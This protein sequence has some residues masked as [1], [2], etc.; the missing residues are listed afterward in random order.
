M[1][2]TLS[3]IPETFGNKCSLVHMVVSLLMWLIVSF[4]WHISWYGFSLSS[5]TELCISASWSWSSPRDRCSTMPA[6]SESPSTL[7]VVRKRSLR[8]KKSNKIYLF[9]KKWLREKT[10]NFCLGYTINLNCCLTS[11][12]TENIQTSSIPN[13]SP[14]RW[15]LQGTHR[16]QSTAMISVMSSVGSPTD[17]NTITMVTRPAWGMPAAP[18]LA[19]VAVILSGRWKG[20]RGVW[21]HLIKGNKQTAY[22]PPSGSSGVM[23]ACEEPSLL[24]Y[25]PKTKLYCSCLIN[26]Y[27]T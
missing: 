5:S 10:P 17:V 26:L 7:V 16:N 13:Q 19:A 25:Y 1:T 21:R 12:L 27:H 15:H 3:L 6:P 18:M 23:K 11:D 24:V 4:S 2:M 14:S 8:P 22:G 9:F 20:W